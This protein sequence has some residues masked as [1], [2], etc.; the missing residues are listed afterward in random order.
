M[1]L[2]SLHNVVLLIEYLLISF[3]LKFP[4]LATQGKVVKYILCN[5]RNTMIVVMLAQVV[6]NVL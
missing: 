2:R 1:L 6:S 5:V 3:P 4:T